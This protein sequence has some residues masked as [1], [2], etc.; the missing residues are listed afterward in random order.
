MKA[1]V[2]RRQRNT[3]KQ[4]RLNAFL[5]QDV[6]YRRVSDLLPFL[7]L[8]SDLVVLQVPFKTFSTTPKIIFQCIKMGIVVWI[9][10][11]PSVS[12]HLDLGIPVNIFLKFTMKSHLVPRDCHIWFFM[13]A[14]NAATYPGVP[15]LMGDIKMLEQLQ[16]R[17]TILLQSAF[18][19]FPLISE[20]SKRLYLSESLV[21]FLTRCSRV[22]SMLPR[23]AGF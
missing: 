23:G 7:S 1:G 4:T 2:R 20:L 11:L 10:C 16:N 8:A 18:S 19:L 5:P 9:F 13:H 17:F 14:A 22:K 21:I 15:L 6:F 12:E 3:W